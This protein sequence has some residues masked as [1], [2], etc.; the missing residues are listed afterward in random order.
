MQKPPALLPPVRVLPW[1]RDLALLLAA[2]LLVNGLASRA[3]THPG[4]VDAYYY[5]GGALQL[6]RGAGFT[7]LYQWNYLAA[8]QPGVAATPPWP[9]HL[10]WMPLTSVVAAPF[11]AAAERLRGTALSNAA[12]FRAAQIPMI[13]LASLL[14]LLSYAVAWRLSRVRRQAWAAALLTLFSPF[15]FVYWSNTDAFAAHGLAA[16]G[17]LLA[18][19]LAGRAGPR[20]RVWALAAGLGA[21]VSHLARADSV[22]VLLVVLLWLAL[23]QRRGRLR[24]AEALALLVL[25]VAGYLAVMGPW[26][27]RNL[28]VV[29]RP[30][31]A[32]GTQTLWLREYNE[33]FNY[34]GGRLSPAHYFGAGGSTLLHGKWDALQTNATT[35]AVVQGGV[36]AF[37][38]ALLGLWR[39]RRAPLVQISL[40]YGLSLFGLMTLAFTFPGAR[41]GYFHSG[42]ALL[43]VFSAATL[44]GLDAVVEAA[45]R[46]LPHWQPRKSIPIFTALLVLSTIALTAVVFGLRVIGPDWRRPAWD[47][48]D[49]VYAQM[50]EWMSANRSSSGLVVANNPPGWTYWTGQPAIVIPNSAVPGLLR[51]MDDY[52][53]RW[54]VLDANYPAGLAELYAQPE[55]EPR[56][57]LRARFGEPDA[58]PVYLLE[59]EP[60]P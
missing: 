13:F 51:V 49:A 46:R 60:A 35:L 22:L 36:V 18:A 34:P 17:A 39:C 11:M 48:Q 5:F 19:T 56:L 29:G 26:F 3:I 45:A 33:L 1:R 14:P 20:R 50:G 2:A 12:L 42:A 41:G 30:L 10:Y 8:G 54:L 15:Y 7:E 24:A 47:R 37:P 31:A 32:G 6:A 40:L 59:R 53:A 4:Y 28:L 38:F 57:T 9:S 23:L 25:V 27:V 55:S 43:P 21:G 44:I 16:A 52:A 58:A